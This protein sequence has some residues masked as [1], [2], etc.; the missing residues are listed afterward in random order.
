PR[1][2]VAVGGTFQIAFDRDNP[3]QLLRITLPAGTDLFPEISGSHHR[4]S[5]RFMTWKDVN[6]R[7]VQTTEDVQFLL[8]QCT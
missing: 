1:P 6:A 3:C 2:E 4:C 8:T 7:P 5:I